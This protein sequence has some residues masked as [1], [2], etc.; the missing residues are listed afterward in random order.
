MSTYQVDIGDLLPELHDQG[1]GL[2]VVLDF[3]KMLNHETIEVALAHGQIYVSIKKIL[4][5]YRHSN[6]L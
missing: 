6:L 4:V 2:L 5:Y 3:D 1:V